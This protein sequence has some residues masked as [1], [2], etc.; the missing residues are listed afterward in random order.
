MADK[1]NDQFFVETKELLEKVRKNNDN[2]AIRWFHENAASIREKIDSKL[3]ELIE[4]ENLPQKAQKAYEAAL[5]KKP[6]RLEELLPESEKDKKYRNPN[7]H[8]QDT[9]WA[10]LGTEAQSPLFMA[11][12]KLKKDV[13]IQAHHIGRHL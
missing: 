1:I 5:I 12:D 4:S 11:Y 8:D 13:E 7:F 9:I 6:N 3:T 2:K 10:I